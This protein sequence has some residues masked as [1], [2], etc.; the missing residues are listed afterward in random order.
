[1]KNKNIIIN[2]TAATLAFAFASLGCGQAANSNTST[3]N[4]SNSNVVAGQG[5]NTT[6][7]PTP[8]ENRTEA[9]SIGSL[10]TPS[11]A[12]RTAHDLRK[13]K[14]IEGLKEV[15][16]S[17]IIE[18]L[19]MMGEEEKKSL[20]DMLKEMCD[21]PQ[22]EKAEVRNEKING[23]SAT[24]EYLTETGSWKTMDFEKIGAE[25]KLGLPQK[26]D[27]TIEGGTKRK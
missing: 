27:L 3:A 4:T 5:S 11:D 18:F 26:D 9:T 23:N 17:D 14:D 16:S 22:A 20:N 10:A 8:T 13:R 15:M 21:K 6:S 1:M 25:W 7:K 12:Y 19:T 24:V 2:A